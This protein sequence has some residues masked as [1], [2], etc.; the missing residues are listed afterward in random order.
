M[1][2][3]IEPLRLRNVRFTIWHPNNIVLGMATIQ[4]QF[5][6]TRTRAKLR[7]LIIDAESANTT[8]ALLAA[9]FVRQTSGWSTDRA[10]SRLQ[11]IQKKY[12]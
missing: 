6:L 2:R 3:V 12:L 5:P 9:V 10:V 1:P 7:A 4:Q 11:E 8:Q